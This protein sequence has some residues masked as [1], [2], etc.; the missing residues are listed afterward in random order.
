MEYDIR[1]GDDSDT[2]SLDL[3]LKTHTLLVD[4]DSNLS[5]NI[6]LKSGFMA[7]Y[8]DN[9]ADPSTGVRRL[10][11]DYEKYDLGVYGISTAQLQDNWLL[12]AGARFD[13]TYMDVFKFYRTSFLGIKKLCCPIS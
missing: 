12:E 11:P 5:E 1:V 8:Q 9:F 3:V 2:P 13:F 6:S 4:I 10:I 7:R